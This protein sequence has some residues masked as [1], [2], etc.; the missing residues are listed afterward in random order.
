MVTLKFDLRFNRI[1]VY[2][3]RE[4]SSYNYHYC[5]CIICFSEKSMT[6]LTL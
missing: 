6:V 5:T 2:D 3:Q 1:Y 4:G